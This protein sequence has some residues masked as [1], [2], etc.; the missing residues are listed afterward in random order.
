MAKISAYKVTGGTPVKGEVTCLGAKNFATKA[1]VC[2]LLGNSP[3]ILTNIPNIGDVDITKRLLET[4]GTKV[5]WVNET[6][7]K[8]DP[9]TVN[10]CKVKTPDSRNN[11]LPILLIPFLLHKYGEA[12]V[13][14]MGGCNIG[15]RNVDFHL[16]AAELFG[17]KVEIKE[18]GYYASSKGRLQSTHYELPYPSVGATES[19]LFLSVLA[20][21]TSVIKNAAVEP[22]IL[23]LITM[24][25]SMGAVIFLS[26]NREITIEGVESLTGTNMYALG[27]RI[28]AA[29]WAALACATDGDITVKGIRPNTLGNFLSYY[30]KV[31]GGFE[32]I[33][34]S[35]IRFFRE[36][37]LT[38]IALETG[39]YPGFSTDWQQ[40]FTVLLTQAK[41]ISVVH[42]TVYEQRFGYT[43]VVN[44]LGSKIQ[45]TT[46][47]LGEACRYENHDYKHSALI[48]GPT[49][50]KAIDE[51]IEIPDL[52]AGL[53]YVIAAAVAEGTSYITNVDLLERGY[54]DIIKRLDKVSLNVEKIEIE[55]KNTTPKNIFKRL[56]EAVGL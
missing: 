38:S 51:P 44:L 35:T 28:E 11:R 25:R 9:T 52:R 12:S 10:T 31:G 53:A 7:L 34:G 26:P 49:P 54:G 23:E 33:G 36:R 37:P 21:G 42:E 27:D 41:G 39:V 56:Q 22:E 1:M 5:T 45:L 24:L 55:V 32:F 16:T 43:Q 4:V 48:M 40:P 50:L 19:C 13:P 2:A 17:A 8:I 14:S 20:E 6:T 15:Q 3:T 30:R 47:C 29:S 18:S 46:K